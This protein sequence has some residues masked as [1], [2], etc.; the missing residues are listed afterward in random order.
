MRVDDVADN[1]GWSIRDGDGEVRVSKAAADLDDTRAADVN[2]SAD[3]EVLD[4]RAA[5][6]PGVPG[7]Q[8][9]ADPRQA[10]HVTAGWWSKGRDRRIALAAS[11]NA[12]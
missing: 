3:P 1:V 10:P 8:E 7:T 11:S 4:A 12:S 5:P 6:P 2:R 9:G